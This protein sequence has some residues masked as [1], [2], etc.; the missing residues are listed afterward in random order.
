MGV[1]WG[2]GAAARKAWAAMHMLATHTPLYSIL[3]IYSFD[4]FSCHLHYSI[5]NYPCQ[6]ILTI[7][8]VI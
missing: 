8:L 5:D 6:Y 4:N 1:A 7:L 2:K 3:C